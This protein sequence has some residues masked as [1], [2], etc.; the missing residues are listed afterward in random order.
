MINKGIKK[1]PEKAMSSLRENIREPTLS[2]D[3]K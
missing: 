1:G 2:I 3:M